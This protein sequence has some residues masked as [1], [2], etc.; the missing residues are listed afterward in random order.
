MADLNYSALLIVLDRSGSMSSIR[1]D[2]VG[3]LEQVLREQAAEPGMLTVDVVTFD[4][5]I[6]HTHVS[7]APEDVRIVLDPRGGT[8]LYDA[9]GIAINGFAQRL[10][11]LP[12][13][14]QPEGVRVVIVTD[15]FENRSTEYSAATV[16]SLIE[17]RREQHGWGFVFLGADQDAVLTAAELGIAADQ[18][19]TY[20]RGAH[21]I[22]AMA[23][24]VS[25]HLSQTRRHEQPQGFTA[26]ERDAAV[27]TD[28][29]GHT[30]GR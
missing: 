20:A 22:G 17:Q 9:V 23:G 4:H 16:R 19:M 2:M 6:E 30:R 21:N 28:P 1:D 15:G 8:A 26:A 18:S 29:D 3:G 12:E 5:E 7:A 24:S 25:R 14:A 27:E 11:A 10:A 13:H